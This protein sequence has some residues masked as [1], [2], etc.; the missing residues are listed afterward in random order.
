MLRRAWFQLLSRIEVYTT[1]WPRRRIG[2]LLYVYSKDRSLGQIEKPRVQEEEY[3]KLH[4]DGA[5]SYHCFLL[6]PIH[7]FSA[8]VTTSR[9]EE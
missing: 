4:L 3:M 1:L 2:M 8:W 6:R 5:A 7:F 9:I